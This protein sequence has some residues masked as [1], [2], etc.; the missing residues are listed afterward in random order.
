MDRFAVFNV[1]EMKVVQVWSLIFLA[2]YRGRISGG[3]ECVLS[4]KIVTLETGKAS[5]EN[6]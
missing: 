3:R 2:K 5:R 1:K 6:W 4:N